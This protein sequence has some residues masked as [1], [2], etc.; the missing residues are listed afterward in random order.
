MDVTQQTE[1]IVRSVCFCV[2]KKIFKSHTVSHTG[3]GVG[4]ATMLS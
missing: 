3:G 4:V 1:R 2:R